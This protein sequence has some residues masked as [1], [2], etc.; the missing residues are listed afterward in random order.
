MQACH[1]ASCAAR[2][3]QAPPE[4][5]PSLVLLTVSDQSS[6]LRLAD[7]LK[8]RGVGRIVFREPDRDNEA[9]ALATVP[10][11]ADKRRLFRHLPLYTAP[12]EDKVLKELDGVQLS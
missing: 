12:E 8:D 3:F 9:T 4:D 7:T 10:L 5:E 6:L 11:A 2:A 1:A